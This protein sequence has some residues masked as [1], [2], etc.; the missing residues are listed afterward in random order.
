MATPTT[1]S[2]IVFQKCHS[3]LMKWFIECKVAIVF[4]VVD[5]CKSLCC[6]DHHMPEMYMQHNPFFLFF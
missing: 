2:H 3:K 6:S 1:S 4:L 5:R